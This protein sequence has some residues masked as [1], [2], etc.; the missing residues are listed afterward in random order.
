VHKQ[1][2][3]ALTG[4]AHIELYAIGGGKVKMPVVCLCGQLKKEQEKGG[5]YQFHFV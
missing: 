2:G 4:N 3:P 1:A 5:N